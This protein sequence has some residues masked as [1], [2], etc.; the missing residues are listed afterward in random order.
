MGQAL[1]LG[2]SAVAAVV[3]SNREDWQFGLFALLLGVAV[4]NGAFELETKQF[5]VSAEFLH[6]CLP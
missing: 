4:I 5:K 6:S 3:V 2:V 1:L